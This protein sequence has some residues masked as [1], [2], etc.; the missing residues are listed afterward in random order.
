[1]DLLDLERFRRLLPLRGG[2]VLGRDSIE[3]SISESKNRLYHY[4]PTLSVLEGVVGSRPKVRIL[5]FLTAEPGRE[6]SQ[7]DIVSSLS[8]STGSLHPAL[9]Q[10]LDVRMVLSRRVGR[11]RL[12]RINERHP[13]YRGLKSLFHQE[14][15]ALVSV[16]REFAGSLSARGVS[17]V[18]LFGS[19][20]RGRPSA[21]RD[22]DILVVVDA[23]AVAD[24]VRRRAASALERFDVN[25]SPLVLTAKKSLA[26]SGPSTPSCQRSRGRGSFCGG[27]P[28]GSDGENGRPPPRSCGKPR[29]HPR[30][31]ATTSRRILDR[32]K[33]AGV[34]RV[35]LG[36]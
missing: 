32:K 22:V 25:L 5:R 16:A 20:A 3:K 1:M 27:R 19:T 10:L 30:R 24:Q 8:A 9:R 35:V 12:F 13:L 7:Q 14:T 11:S 4:A 21:R 23:P 15:T 17:A 2:R 18:I 36:G 28:R 33:M 34:A 6:F 26:G 31:L 29:N